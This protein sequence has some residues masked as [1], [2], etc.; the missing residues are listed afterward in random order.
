[1]LHI[2]NIWADMD[3]HNRFLTR[4]EAKMKNTIYS[5]AY[6]VVVGAIVAFAGQVGA[7][8][9]M[10]T[11]GISVHEE[12]KD[13]QLVMGSEP[14]NQPTLGSSPIP[15]AGWDISGEFDLKGPGGYV[16]LNVAIEDVDIVPEVG[17]R[18]GD[19]I[20]LC[21]KYSYNAS[22]TFSESSAS[23]MAGIGGGIPSYTFEGWPFPD[24]ALIGFPAAGGAF[25]VMDRNQ[26]RYV[27][28]ISVGPESIYGPWQ[29]GLDP[30]YAH[31]SGDSI[32]R[33]G[34]TSV[35]VRIGDSLRLQGSV[36]M[37]G[38]VSAEGSF[39]SS[40]AH[41]TGEFSLINPKNKNKK[42]CR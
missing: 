25:K 24:S 34:T 32:S 3:S 7:A 21:F 9:F 41:F 35:L 31:K 15:L 16:G 37:A 10:Q 27:P 36:A 4:D 17:E 11:G 28:L 2:N 39:A 33:Q 30:I 38:T 6:L 19:K 26:N 1:M 22:V 29:S 20:T 42:A 18:I 12:Y 5:P 13:G 8:Q 23:A 40:E 14:S